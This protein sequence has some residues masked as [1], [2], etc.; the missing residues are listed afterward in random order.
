MLYFMPTCTR[1]KP[2]YTDIH[3]LR[4]FRV[5][6]V[7]NSGKDGYGRSTPITELSGGAQPFLYKYRPVC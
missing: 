3:D 5:R 6:Y 1:F 4:A 7:A 2:L